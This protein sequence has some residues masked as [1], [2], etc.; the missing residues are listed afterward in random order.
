[1]RITRAI[2]RDEN[3]ILPVGAALNGEY[4]LDD[5]FIGTPGI[6]NA[7]GLAGVIEVPLSEA[8]Q[9]KMKASADTLKKVTKD[10]FSGTK[11]LIV[12]QGLLYQD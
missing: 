11:R 8:E 3:A 5:I 7:T 4:G 10:G 1:M 6:I 12:S 9:A 2:F